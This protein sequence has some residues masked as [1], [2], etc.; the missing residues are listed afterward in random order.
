MTVC[1]PVW[2]TSTNRAPVDWSRHTTPSRLTVNRR[3][4]RGADPDGAPPRSARQAPA[5]L[6]GAEATSGPQGQGTGRASRRARIG[7]VKFWGLVCARHARLAA[8]ADERV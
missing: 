8:A 6:A 7:L 5:R 3:A 2:S 4:T 1:V